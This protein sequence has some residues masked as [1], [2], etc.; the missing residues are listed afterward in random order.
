VRSE[1][2]FGTLVPVAALDALDG[3]EQTTFEAHVQSCPECRRDLETDRAL[4]HR[5]PLALPECRPSAALRQRV[6][7]A[8]AAEGAGP[9]PV[10][11]GP[12]RRPTWL[13]SL[14]AL[15]AA[16]SVVLGVALISARH[17]RD[18]ARRTADAVR[19]TSESLEAQV[20][21]AREQLAQ[22]RPQ[23]TESDATRADAA[24]L[25][26]ASR[27]AQNRLATLEQRLAEELGRARQTLAAREQE[28]SE[29]REAMAR[30]EQR[31]KAE[32][33]TARQVAS[34][35]EAQVRAVQADLADTRQRLEREKAF[36]E[37]VAHPDSR[38][39]QLTG[40]AAGSRAR[41]RVVW[42][43]ASREAVLMVSGL[44]KAP[45]GKGYEVWVVSKETTVPAGVFQVDAEGSALFRLPTLDETERVK[46]FAVT[47]EP[48]A[49]RA[50]PSGPMVLAG[51]AP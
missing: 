43:P 6:L 14:V 19:S 45:D 16:A 11:L 47:L 25:E 20:Q 39:A 1:D 35:L 27:E 3:A 4:A 38:V 17:E 9:R 50:A 37:L 21:R 15:P 34:S 31:F 7:D 41:A 8:I 2:R 49:G 40:V 36:R 24:S 26:Q 30:S 42:N 23:Q 48:A 12:V 32:A 51:A 28:A 29:A 46:T 33:D 22:A 10:P 44:P 5:L 18:E 13:T